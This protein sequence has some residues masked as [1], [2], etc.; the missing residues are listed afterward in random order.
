MRFKL[1]G[2]SG[3]RVSELSLGTM[4]F[5][6]DWAWGASK[7]VSH[8]IFKKF[9]EA[10]GNFIDTACNYTNGSSEKFIGEFVKGDRDR[11]VIATKYTLVDHRFKKDPNASGNHRK[12][13]IRSLNDSLKRLDTDYIDILYVHMWDH[14]TPVQEIMRTLNDLIATTKVNYI[15]ISDTPAWIVS[16]ANTM[17]EIRGWN[18]FVVYQFPYNLGA[19]DPERDIIPLCNKFDL[20]MAP[21]DVLGAGLF[22][23]KYTRSE[24]TPEGRIQEGKWTPISEQKSQLAKEVDAIADEIGCSSS[25]VA[26]NWIRG[27]EGV[28]TPIVGFRKVDQIEDVLNSLDYKLSE[29]HYQRL[30]KKLR[31]VTN[32]NWGFPKGWLV[33]ARGIIYGDTYDLTDNHRPY[34][35]S[36]R[37][38]KWFREQNK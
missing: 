6:E 31:E 3:L 33:G 2:K 5:G 32:F 24:T 38:E 35:Y 37:F 14:F 13:L 4:T 36:S 15:G 20:A 22:T 27:Q 9:S 17:A 29:E 28:F 10:G 26:V 21:F 23:G 18:P 25:N 1:L 16:R 8:Q 19:R 30:D 11:Y 12:N 34:G 7:E